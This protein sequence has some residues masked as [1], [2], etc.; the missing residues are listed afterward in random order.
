M[1]NVLSS[2][3][4]LRRS[5]FP[6][7]RFSVIYISIRSVIVARLRFVIP[8]FLL[9]PRSVG[10]LDDVVQ[11]AY[12]GIKRLQIIVHPGH[13][14]A[15][16]HQKLVLRPVALSPVAVRRTRRSRTTMGSGEYSIRDRWSAALR[17][18]ETGTG[19][20]GAIACV[21]GFPRLMSLSRK[22]GS[23]CGYGRGPVISSTT[24]RNTRLIFLAR[25][26]LVE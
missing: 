21:F 17:G 7:H 3:L 16:V 11:G 14:F 10:A 9:A 19:I 15:K 13:A 26:A 20:Y 25:D 22:R 2:R 5:I 23:R 24:I 12:V 4:P 8:A 6:G 18:G 1:E